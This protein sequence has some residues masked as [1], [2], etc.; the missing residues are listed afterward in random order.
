MSYRILAL[1]LAGAVYQAAGQAGGPVV[2]PLPTHGELARRQAER[3][4]DPKIALEK[5]PKPMQKI[6]S[7]KTDSILKRSTIL[8]FRGYWTFVPK[9]AVLHVPAHFRGRV[10]GPR[11]GRLLTWREFLAKNRAW[12]RVQPVTLANARG[13]E[14]LPEEEVRQHK[15]I[16]QVVVATCHGGPISVKPPKAPDPPEQKS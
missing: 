11:Q 15:T 7:D 2:R 10:G 4:I 9:E 5:D 1:L 13:E 3:R 16:G 8:S 14:P 6:R 12:L